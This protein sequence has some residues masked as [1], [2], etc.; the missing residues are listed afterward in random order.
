MDPV[1]QHTTTDHDNLEALLASFGVFCDFVELRLHF[2]YDSRYC[3]GASDAVEYDGIVSLSTEKSFDIDLKALALLVPDLRLCAEITLQPDGSVTADDLHTP[4][5]S[6][7]S[8]LGSMAVKI[9]SSRQ[10]TARSRP[11]CFRETQ[12]DKIDLREQRI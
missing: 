8:H 9:L 10:H 6:I 7:E 11:V 12:P 1:S 3:V 4:F 2:P 5:E